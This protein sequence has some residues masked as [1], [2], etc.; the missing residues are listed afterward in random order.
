VFER[1]KCPIVW[2]IES[3]TTRTALSVPQ[4]PTLALKVSSAAD[5]NTAANTLS[6]HIA[7]FV[8]QDLRTAL[9]HDEYGARIYHAV[10]PALA[11]VLSE[12]LDNVFSHAANQEFI[13]PIAWVAAQYYPDGDLMRVAVVDDGCGLLGSLRNIVEAAPRNH[14]EAAVAAFT[15]FVS[16]KS[17]PNIYAERRHMGIGLSV[18][19]D[20]C[21]K[22]DGRIYSVSGNAQLINAG[23]EGREERKLVKYFQGTIISLEFHRQAASNRTLRDALDTYAKTPSVDVRFK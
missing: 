7:S 15:P 3:P 6:E 14:F 13:D 2:G 18:C 1:M 11:H 8:P 16:S 20:L 5:A 19:R 9:L 21:Q 17:T 10:Q 23:V 22:L 12:L 4:V